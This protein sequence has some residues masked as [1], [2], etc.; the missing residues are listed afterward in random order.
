MRGE[1]RKEGADAAGRMSRLLVLRQKRELL[2]KNFRLQIF[3]TFLE[4]RLNSEDSMDLW[5]LL[6]CP[7]AATYQYTSFAYTLATDS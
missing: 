7:S 2:T 4:G 3:I 5:K 6:F 1:S